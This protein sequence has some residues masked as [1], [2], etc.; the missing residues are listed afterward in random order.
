MEMLGYFDNA[1]P[2]DYEWLLQHFANDEGTW[3]AQRYNDA[4]RDLDGVTI[5]VTDVAT[6]YFVEKTLRRELVSSDPAGEGTLAKSAN[7]VIRLSFLTRISLPAGDALV[8]TPVGGGTDAGANFSY[9]V[10]SD[11][12]TLKAVENGTALTN[13]TWYRIRPAAGFDVQPF[14]LEL[15]TLIGDADGSGQVK[16]LDLGTIWAHKNEETD[17]RYDIDGSGQVKALD[18]GDCWDHKNEAV[19]AKP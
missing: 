8:I 18:L 15:C 11:G 6:G 3:L 16:A 19:P 10:E 13:Q 2:Y 14:A 7:N 4:D 1:D 17:A 5:R 12:M 9:A